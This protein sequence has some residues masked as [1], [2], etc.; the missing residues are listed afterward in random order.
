MSVT[1]SSGPIHV[2]TPLRTATAAGPPAVPE[3]DIVLLGV[4]P[5]GHVASLF[6]GHATLHDDTHTVVG[7]A[8]SPKPPP[9][10]VSLTYPAIRAARE[11]WLVVAGE[12]KA[13]AVAAA[14]A[15]ASVDEI[16]AAGALG[17][18]RTLWLLDVAAASKIRTP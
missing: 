14:L 17:T 11:V 12:E 18:E 10:R 15:G 3:L 1:R 16:P 5:D 13:E 9:R 6:P 7:E 4:G 2:T 8:D